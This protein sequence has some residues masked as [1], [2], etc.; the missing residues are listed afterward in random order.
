MQPQVGARGNLSRARGSRASRSTFE[1]QPQLSQGRRRWLVIFE[2]RTGERRG[3]TRRCG[4][5]SI[6]LNHRRTSS[7]MNRPR[8]CPEGAGASGRA[9]LLARDKRRRQR[10]SGGHGSTRQ[11]GAVDGRARPSRAISHPPIGGRARYPEQCKGQQTV[12]HDRPSK[13]RSSGRVTNVPDLGEARSIRT[14]A[15]A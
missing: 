1:R 15:A 8:R 2:A 7:G 13:A 9:P 6:R 12:R 4:G 10:G 11:L 5:S 14:V 3:G